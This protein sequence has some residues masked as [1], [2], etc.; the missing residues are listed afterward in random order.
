MPAIMLKVCPPMPKKMHLVMTGPS[1][2]GKSTIVKHIQTTYPS[3]RF[4]VSHTTRRPREK[5]VEGRDYYFV[6]REEFELM[7]ANNEL[8]ELTEYNGNYY[9]TSLSQMRD[10][11]I[12]LL[13]LEYEGVKYCLR[14]HRMDFL[15][16]YVDC[17]RRTAYERLKGRNGASADDIE[18]RMSLY[19]RFSEIR[20]DCDYVIDN[21]SDLEKAKAG[22]ERFVRDRYG[23]NK[24][25]ESAD[26]FT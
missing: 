5:E 9:G 24:S 12:L 25:P 16:V 11:G 19:D 7:I 4:S 3:F 18:S 10:G 23:L 13:D 26:K 21:S 1:G 17:D 15:I 8:L 20:N 22:I 14:N 2:S 6:T